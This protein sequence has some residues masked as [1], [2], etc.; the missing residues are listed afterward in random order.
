MEQQIVANIE[1]FNPNIEELVDNVYVGPQAEILQDIEYFNSR[2]MWGNMK[3]IGVTKKF[4]WKPGT[5]PEIKKSMDRI[6]A[7]D[8]KSNSVTNLIQRAEQRMYYLRQMRTSI[9][10]IENK[11]TNK[12]ASGS[13]FQDNT[14]NIIKAWDIVKNHLIECLAERYLNNISINAYPNNHDYNIII[15]YKRE[16][17]DIIYQDHGEDIAKVFYPGKVSI[18]FKITLTSLLNAM[19]AGND[20]DYRLNNMTVALIRASYGGV[21]NNEFK[22]LHPFISASSHHGYDGGRYNENFRYVCLGNMTNDILSCI[23]C[24]DIKFADFYIDRL[25]THFDTQT[26]PLNSIHKSYHGM[27]ESMMNDEWVNRLGSNNN[28]QNIMSYYISDDEQVYR[29]ANKDYCDNWC[30]LKS[31]CDYYETEGKILNGDYNEE[32]VLKDKLAKTKTASSIER[33][34]VEALLTRRT[35]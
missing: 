11:L 27:Q 33:R 25:I 23:K 16:N 29:V 28:C 20:G 22:L 32:K 6:L 13:I 3:D 15:T 24:L 2:Y 18:M 34:T 26:G 17:F 1:D 4:Y 31:S 9:A 21:T 14:E 35:L 5:Y 19:L 8:R 10:Q 12:R 7:T 30:A